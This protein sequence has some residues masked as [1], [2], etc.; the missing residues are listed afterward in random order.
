MRFGAIL[1]VFV[2]FLYP[3]A[4]EIYELESLAPHQLLEKLPPAL[5]LGNNTIALFAYPDPR[6]RSI[7]HELKYRRNTTLTESLATILYDVIKSE[8]SERALMENF[9]DPLLVPMPMSRERYLER[10]WNQTEII[11]EEIKKLDTGNILEYAPQA[12]RKIKHTESQTLIKNKKERLEN[13]IDSMEAGNVAKSR[14][15]ILLDDVTT[16][17]ASFAEAKKKLRLSGASKILCIALAH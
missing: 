4:S 7:I 2:D 14:C 11:C 1:S 12:L 9:R 3:K 15:V 17:G 13:L 5:D 6:V 8:L 16:T 10:G